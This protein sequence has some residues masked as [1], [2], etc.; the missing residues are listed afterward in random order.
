MTNYAR[1]SR[2]GYPFSHPPLC[3]S[4]FFSFSVAPLTRAL[5]IGWIDLKMTDRP[6]LNE[7]TTET[8]RVA[9]S[10]ASALPPPPPSSKEECLARVSILTSSRRAPDGAP[11]ISYRGERVAAIYRVART[12]TSAREASR[13]CRL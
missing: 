12:D 2:T 3:L 7:T 1:L 5:F 13:V 10:S 6:T 9:A 11:A 4:L 8:A